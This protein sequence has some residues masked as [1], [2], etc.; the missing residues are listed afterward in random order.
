[1]ELG[2]TISSSIGLANNEELVFE[3]SKTK[4][5]S[6][7]QSHLIIFGLLNLFVIQQDTPS[8]MKLTAERHKLGQ[9]AML[10]E[11]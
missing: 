1:M 8:N 10:S 4:K 7:G 11:T 3:T 9:A 5:T 6:V 2:A